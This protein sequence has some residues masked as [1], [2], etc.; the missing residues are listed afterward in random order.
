[1]KTSVSK[2]SKK[3]PHRWTSLSKL[4]FVHFVWNLR[5][6]IN[7]LSIVWYASQEKM[8]RDK[9]IQTVQITAA[10]V[11]S[12][13]SSTWWT[14]SMDWWSLMISSVF[15][16]PI[17]YIMCRIIWPYSNMNTYNILDLQERSISVETWCGVQ[18]QLVASLSLAIKARKESSAR[19]V[20]KKHAW[21]V[22][23]LGIQEDHV[24]VLQKSNLGGFS[25]RM[26]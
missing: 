21:N 7:P 15:V 25:V 13:C 24:G 4:R 8:K 16:V 6:C 14:K 9:F 22:T 19:T 12:V 1:M 17:V 5:I 26:M 18:I 20:K 23:N 11:V 10:V 3:L 2:W